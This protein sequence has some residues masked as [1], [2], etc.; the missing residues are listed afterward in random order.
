RNG[1]GGERF[2]VSIAQCGLFRGA[3]R[4]V[5][6]DD[7]R[8]GIFE[9]GGE[10]ARGFK[11]YKIVIRKLFALELFCRAETAGSS[12]CWDVEG[13]GL[14]RIFSIAQFLL[15]AQS[16]MYAFRKDWPRGKFDLMAAGDET[17]EFR[18]D[19]AVVAGCDSK[20]LAG[21][22]E[23]RGERSLSVRFEFGRNAV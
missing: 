11:V 20:N 22:F 2:Q 15:H 6:L 9:F 21:E 18:S 4:V 12:A 1:I 10:A 23:T 3:A 19:E 16:E 13:S 14:M 8:S 7:D 5:V 17:F